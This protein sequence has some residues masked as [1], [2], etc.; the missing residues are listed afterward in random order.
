MNSPHLLVCAAVIAGVSY[1][2]GAGM[3]EAASPAIASDAHS[4]LSESLST[5]DTML[6]RS[7]EVLESAA[8]AD[9]RP[10]AMKPFRELQIAVLR[11]R[12]VLVH[13]CEMRM[14][15]SEFCSE[16]YAPEWLNNE[17]MTEPD[18]VELRARI[19]DAEAHIRP[20]WRAVCAH[21]AMDGADA[22]T[23]D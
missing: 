15:G 10:V 20:F 7:E 5:I 2:S 1:L 9:P 3:R 8:M 11:Y 14:A 19:A 22:C 17:P 18:E 21:E 13:A 4:E 12:L 6:D 16:P 23:L